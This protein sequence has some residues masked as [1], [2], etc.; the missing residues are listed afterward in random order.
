[1]GRGH[2]VIKF[3]FKPRKIFVQT[4]VAR[5]IVINKVYTVK[6]VVWNKKPYFALGRKEQPKTELAELENIPK[7]L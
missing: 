1:M 5:R 6:N 7:M 2:F 4:K 3:N